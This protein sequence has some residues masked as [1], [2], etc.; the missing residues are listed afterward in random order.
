VHQAISYLLSPPCVFIRPRLISLHLCHPQTG[1][2]SCL[3][4]SSSIFSTHMTQFPPGFLSQRFFPRGFPPPIPADSSPKGVLRLL[5]YLNTTPVMDHFPLPDPLKGYGSFKRIGPPNCRASLL[6]SPH[7]FIVVPTNITTDSLPEIGTRLY[8]LF[9]PP[10]WFPFFT[11]DQTNPLS[12][13]NNPWLELLSRRR[14]RSPSAQ[15]EG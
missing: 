2:Q 6:A 4:L 3:A 13:P 8:G 12:P 10:P 1:H 14:S 15:L 11:P 9:P 5:V 7:Y